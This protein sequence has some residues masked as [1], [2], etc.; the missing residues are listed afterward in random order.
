VSTIRF[1]G[2]HPL[3]SG[4]V[5]MKWRRDRRHGLPLENPFLFY[6]RLTI[7]IARKIYGYA[8]LYVDAK[9]ILDDVTRAPERN[10]YSDLAIAPQDDELEKLDLYH[11]TRGGE[12][13]LARLRREE[14]IRLVTDAHAAERSAASA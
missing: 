8:K 7:E 3:E 5:R 13:A 4:A 10:S 12:E 1:E 9:K 2:V 14:R 6:P 11:A